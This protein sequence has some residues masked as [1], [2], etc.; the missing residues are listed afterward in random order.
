M[1]EIRVKVPR[2]RLIGGRYYWRPS[3]AL[4][5]EGYQNI[6]LGE[7]TA[8]A[9][10]K[11]QAL[12]RR[13]EREKATVKPS[14]LP[15]SVADV[16][17]IYGED[18]RFTKLAEDTKRAYRCVLREIEANG[19]DLDIADLD[20]PWFRALY[21]RLSVRG[22]PIARLHMVVWSILMEVARDEGFRKDNPVAKMP[23]HKGEARDRR[24]TDEERATFCAAAERLGRPSIALAVRLA[25]D[26]GQRER[27]VLRLTWHNYGGGAFSFRQTKTGKAVGVPVSAETRAALDAM[28]RTGVH[29]VISEITGQPYGGQAFRDAFAT[30]RRKAGLPADLQFRDLRRTALSEIGEAGGT[31]DEIRAVSGHK[32]RNVVATYVVPTTT[33]AGNAQAKRER[34]RNAS[35]KPATVNGEKSN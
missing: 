31:D 30:I 34:A 32:S 13:V 11:A 2:L 21:R 7:D 28:D 33:M 24:W 14:T 8:S 22:K 23:L 17:R 12:N 9:V 6:P 4:R 19:G 18:A 29:V 1:G 10:K 20:R 35:G 27:D 25:Y 3:K 15:G 16:I 5:A 26:L